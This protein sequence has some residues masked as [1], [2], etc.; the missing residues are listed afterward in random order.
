MVIDYLRNGRINRSGAAFANLIGSAILLIM[1]H[2]VLGGMLR[3]TLDRSGLSLLG[4]LP[5]D[6]AHRRHRRSHSLSARYTSGCTRRCYG[7]E[8]LIEDDDGT[9]GLDASRNWWRLP[10]L[11]GHDCLRCRS[12]ESAP[13]V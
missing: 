12:S 6:D 8:P 11:T 9:N 10:R 3:Y 5:D 7:L 13:T 1:T 2:E 4:F